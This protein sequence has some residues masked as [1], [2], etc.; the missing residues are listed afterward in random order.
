MRKVKTL[1]RR[2][3]MVLLFILSLPLR[4]MLQDLSGGYYASLSE[5][6]K[7][8]TPTLIPGAVDENTK[9][10][11][12]VEILPFVQA[13]HTGE[14]IRWLRKGT[15][16]E[17][18]VA[19]I[20]IGGTTIFSEAATFDAQTATL[21]IA[22]L[23]CKLD[24]YDNAIWQTV[25][26]YEDAM[27]EG[28]MEDVTKVLGKKIIYDDY[29]YDANKLQMDG[30]HAWAA[31]N[32]GQAWDIDGNIEALALEDLRIIKDE[33]KHGIDFWLMPFAIARQIDRVYREMGIAAM[34]SAA[35]AGALG[36]ISYAVNSEGGRTTLFDNIPIVRTDYL[37][38]EQVDTGQ[39]SNARA[40]FSSG[41]PYYSIFGIK[42]GQGLMTKG[43][44]GVKVAFGKTESDGEFFN[45]EYFDRLENYIG[46]AMRVATYTQMIVGSKYAIG[47]ITDIPN[48]VPVAST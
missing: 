7:A 31:T 8:T 9:R 32:W 4:L 21:R 14:Y 17:D 35:G 25:N 10:G 44:P 40:T 33:M 48:T 36:L 42:L 28:M 34:G 30:L 12:P 45:V 2:V 47:R 6:L 43:D 16:L 1:G 13:N 5:V 3:G 20:G 26:N 38:Q 23:M 27:A 37:V 41:T 39:G 18:N 15:T 24:K 11:N 46:K 29:S 22:Y 19:D